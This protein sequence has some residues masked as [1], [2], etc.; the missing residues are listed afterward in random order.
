M[1][2]KT[3]GGLVMTLNP[4][5]VA[6]TGEAVGVT[7][8]VGTPLGEGDSLGVGEGDGEVWG[9]ASANV[10]QGFGGTL[11]QS[12]CGPGASPAKG[13]TRVL[14]LPPPSA[15]AEPATLFAWSQ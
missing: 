1:G 5:R 6:A 9:P 7:S 10:A 13:L 12:L 2:R 4:L 3:K 8:V 11:A 15:L 14:K